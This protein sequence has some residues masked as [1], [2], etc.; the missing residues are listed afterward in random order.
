MNITYSFE[1]PEGNKVANFL[2]IPAVAYE[3]SIELDAVVYGTY[4]PAT[5]D[6]PAEYPELEIDS[7][8][9]LVISFYVE[10]TNSTFDINVTT[11]QLCILVEFKG[12]LEPHWND[13]E[14]YLWELYHHN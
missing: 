12:I 2:A 6:F 8:Y 7:F 5:W 3:A 14:N 1:L 11:D 4:K 9:N 10:S 13:I